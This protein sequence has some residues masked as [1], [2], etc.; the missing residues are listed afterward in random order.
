MNC[1]HMRAIE[2]IMHDHVDYHAALAI[3]VGYGLVDPLAMGEVPSPF[4]RALDDS[5]RACLDLGGEG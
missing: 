2:R 4:D 1:L 5:D 3:A